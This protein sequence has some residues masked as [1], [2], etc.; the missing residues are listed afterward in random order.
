[1]IVGISRR[2]RRIVDFDRR[3]HRLATE[4]LRAKKYRP[5]HPATEAS[6]ELGDG[7][8]TIPIRHCRDAFFRSFQSVSH[9]VSNDGVHFTKGMCSPRPLF[10]RAFERARPARRVSV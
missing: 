2:E 10:G 4:T 7:R 8:A 3:R 9:R 5:R 6:G 1:M